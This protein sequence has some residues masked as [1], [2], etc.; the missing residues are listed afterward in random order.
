MSQLQCNSIVPVGGV[1]AG[2]NGGGIIQ[3]VQLTYSTASTSSGISAFTNTPFGTLS[4]TPRSTNSKILLSANFGFNV[5]SLTSCAFRFTRNGTVIGGS[6]DTYNGS[7]GFGGAGNAAWRVATNWQYLDSPASTSA[8]SYVLQF[9]PYDSGRT[10]YWNYAP[11]T[12][13]DAFTGVT[14]LFAMEVSG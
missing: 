12:A 5:A 11:G 8:L 10:V 1:P 13:L 9:L 7:F 2:A 4:I 6:G 3:V 14:T